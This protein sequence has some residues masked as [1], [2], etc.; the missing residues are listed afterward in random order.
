MRKQKLSKDVSRNLKWLRRR[1]CLPRRGTLSE[2]VSDPTVW[3]KKGS[4]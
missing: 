4:L 1:R 2:E 3:I